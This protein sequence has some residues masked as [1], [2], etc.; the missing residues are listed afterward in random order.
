MAT[1][2]IVDLQNEV[3]NLRKTIDAVNLT[4]EA[5]NHQVK[6]I[7][8]A[9]DFDVFVENELAPYF[10]DSTAKNIIGALQRCRLNGNNYVYLSPVYQWKGIYGDLKKRQLLKLVSAVYRIKYLN[11]KGNSNISTIKS[12]VKYATECPECGAFASAFYNRLVAEGRMK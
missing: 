2:N 3:L 7:T 9:E 4:I 1:T 8:E 5:L 10:G 12:D 6:T 11:P